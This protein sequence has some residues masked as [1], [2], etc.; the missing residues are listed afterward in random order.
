MLVKSEKGIKPEDAP[1]TGGASFE[2]FAG[3]EIK[4]PRMRPIGDSLC[5]AVF[6]GIPMDIIDM[7]LKISVVA[8]RMFPK[9]ALPK[10]IFTTFVAG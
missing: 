4:R 7:P 10:P 5:P 1:T 8:N 9:S 3:I 6:D 2:S